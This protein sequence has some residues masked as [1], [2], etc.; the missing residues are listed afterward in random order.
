MDFESI[1]PEVDEKQTVKNVKHFLSVTLPRM[2]TISYKKITD[3][4]SPVISDLPK[5]PSAGNSAEMTIY[6]KLYAEQVVV[7]CKQ[8]IEHCDH[9]SQVI[10]KRLFIESHMYDYR[11]MGELGYAE[12]R[13]YF[14]KN[15]ACLMFADAYLLDDLHSYVK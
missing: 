2:E 3:L 10:L 12:N 8:A 9:I 1:F 14:Y 5:A 7:R 13:F 4:K 15:R 6:K 11:L